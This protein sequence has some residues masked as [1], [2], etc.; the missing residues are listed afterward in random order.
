[1][2]TARPGGGELQIELEPTKINFEYSTVSEPG[3]I[4]ERAVQGVGGAWFV[5]RDLVPRALDRHEG[6]IHR[7]TA[8]KRC[9]VAGL[10]VH[11]QYM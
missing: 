2:C 6:K 5:R 9:A 11:A 7:R 4:E 8:K 3:A 10:H 1:M